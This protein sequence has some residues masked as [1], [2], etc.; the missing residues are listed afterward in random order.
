MSRNN[1]R[2]SY[3]VQLLQPCREDDTFEPIRSRS[4]LLRAAFVIVSVD[5]V[6]VDVCARDTGQLPCAAL[7]LRWKL[8]KPYRD[9]VG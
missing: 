9:G 5:F 3:W 2:N 1:A 4:Q 8:Q 7:L 6:F